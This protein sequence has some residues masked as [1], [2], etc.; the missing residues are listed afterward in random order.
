MAIRLAKADGHLR[1]VLHGASAALI[2]KFAAATVTYAAHVLVARLY[3]PQITGVFF[4]CTTI[5]LFASSVG[6]L[7]M[8]VSLVR[9]IARAGTRAELTA[10]TAITKNGLRIGICGSGLVAGSALMLTW[11]YSYLVPGAQVDSYALALLSVLPVSIALICAA[12]L[13]G[14]KRVARSTALVS[15]NAQ[16][17]FICLLVGSQFLLVRGL[18]PLLLWLVAWCSNALLAILWVRFA[19]HSSSALG[20][21][22]ADT[23]PPPSELLASGIPLMGAGLLTLTMNWSPLLL[24]GVLGDSADV[25]TFGAASKT[26]FLISFVLTAVNSIA[27]PKFAALHRQGDIVELGRLARQ[28]A[29]LLTICA[30]PFL[31]LCTV[32]PEQVMGMFGQDFRGAA[33]LLAILAIG[34]F[35]NVASGSVGFL[36]SMTGHE[37]T[38]RNNYA[39][40]AFLAAGTGL[41]LIPL[42]GATGAAIAA[43]S[44]LA[45]QNILCMRS[46]HRLLGIRTL[47]FGL[48]THTSTRA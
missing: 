44:A 33:H 20:P 12:V 34:Q 30:L 45:A 5:I 32:W 24:L 38:L 1:E 9:F 40:T 17:I 19:L 23:S 37:K 8:D 36:L 11:T 22:T 43:A 46:V 42:Y 10:L 21:L 41:V 18:S 15:L 29:A 31:V 27:A 25:A 16:G 39:V 4:L 14:M 35:I 26:A 28:C 48:Y 3:G 13:R 7:G 2:V 47:P 6:R